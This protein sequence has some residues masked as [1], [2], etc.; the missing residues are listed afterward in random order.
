MNASRDHDEVAEKMESII[1]RLSV[2]EK[3]QTRVMEELHDLL[4]AR[5]K[6]AVHELSEYLNSRDIRARFTSW[7]L[8]EVPKVE[9]SWEVIKSNISKAL[10]SRLQEIIEHWEED[11][12]VFSDARKVSFTTLSEAVQ[13]C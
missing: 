13:I 8:D 9:S 11:N 7:T 4:K 5:V 6:D 10:E 2:I 3:Q 1:T 12:Q